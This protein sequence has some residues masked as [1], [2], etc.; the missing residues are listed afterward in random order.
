VNTVLCTGDRPLAGNEEPALGAH[1]VTPRFGYTHHGVYVG[2]G[3]VVHYGAFAFQWRRGPVQ[4]TSLSHF[5]DRRPLWVRPTGPGGLDC[6]EIVRR[7]R[8]RLGEKKYRLFSNNC[9]HFSEW[10]VNGVHRSPQVDR[11]R[12]R[13]RSA[14]RTLTQ[15]IPLP[16]IAPLRRSDSRS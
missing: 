14:L 9:E 6:G 4:E 15:L 16:E 2:S 11:I 7:A 3:T 5:A 10:C 13:V 12:M 8:S 1:L